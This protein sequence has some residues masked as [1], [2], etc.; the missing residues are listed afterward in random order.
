M[1]SR[2]AALPLVVLGLL[3]SLPALAAHAQ[4]DLNCS[5]FQY[6]QEAQEKLDRNTSDPN[7]LDGDGDGVA[8]D[9]LPDRPAAV[10]APAGA[11]A[12]IIPVPAPPPAAATRSNDLASTGPST[13]PI[14]IAGVAC[15]AFGGWLLA[16]GKRLRRRERRI[17]RAL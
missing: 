9:T 8:C 12:P 11:A 17:A 14:A 15:L 13:A 4:Q 16:R 7:G 1:R 10:Q 5:D 6:Q 3:L 2:T